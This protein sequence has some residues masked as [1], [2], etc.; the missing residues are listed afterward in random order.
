MKYFKGTKFFN[1]PF[2]ISSLRWK[3]YWTLKLSLTDK[4]NVFIW[5]TTNWEK[6][7]AKVDVSI[8][9]FDI[10]IIEN[11]NKPF[12]PQPKK[13][14]WIL[15]IVAASDG[16]LCLDVEKLFFAVQIFYRPH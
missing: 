8:Q 10:W 15:L 1:S 9:F 16:S 13:E 7:E 12:A 2:L 11:V 3:I 6:I 4:E 14:L 5:M